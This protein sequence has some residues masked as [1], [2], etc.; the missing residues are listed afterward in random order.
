MRRGAN[1]ITMACMATH[2]TTEQSA[3][4]ATG[5]AVREACRSGTLT[6]P[7]S[8]FAAGFTQ[9]NLV[10]VPH[11]AAFEF[12]LFCQRNPKPCP[13]LEVT[14]PGDYVPRRFAP[15]ADL[16]TDLPRYRVWR[17]G[18]L[19]GEP[20][21][22][23]DLWQSDFVAFL[24]GCSFTFEAALQAAGIPVRHIEQERNVPMYR[25]HRPCAPAGRFSGPLVV[26]MRPMT[27]AQSVVA[28]Q[29]TSRF[30]GVHGA[31]VHLGDPGAL[32]ISDLARP[33]F[34]DPVEVRAGEIPV[35]WA[36]GVTP[37]CALMAAKLPLA[38]TH[39]PGCM[40]VTDG[41]DESLAVG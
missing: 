37:Q 5:V 14:E 25:T 1:L 38:I 31:P 4:L 13:V 30:P 20:T 22:I 2:A 9:A 27:A 35:F 21:E 12:L 32:G 23:R 24:I 6:G 40:F 19:A 39:A 33:D 17:D 29:V 18:E 8:G 7:T 36:C 41:G 10:I 11:A 16:R 15:E 26:S 28:V 3:E 34:G